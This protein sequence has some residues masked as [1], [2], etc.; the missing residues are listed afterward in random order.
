MAPKMEDY[1]DVLEVQHTATL[2]E[3]S[4][5]YRKLALA[6][7]PDKNPNKP[8]A[9]ASFQKVGHFPGTSSFNQEN[10]RLTVIAAVCGL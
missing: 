3:I 7:H 10:W 1:Y 4:A 8:D 5:S 6:L 2:E 9:T